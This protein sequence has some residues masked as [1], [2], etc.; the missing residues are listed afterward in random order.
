ML[1]VDALSRLPSPANETFELDMCIEHHAFTKERVRQIHADTGADQIL[2]IV[3]N[4]TLE[5]W[6]M[7]R[8]R[9]P[10]IAR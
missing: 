5:G 10:H 1:L 7:R 8:C 3:Y 2:A 6:P 9:V 4:F